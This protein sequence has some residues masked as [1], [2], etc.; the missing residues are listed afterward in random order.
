MENSIGK[1]IKNKISQ[2][3]GPKV[4]DAQSAEIFNTTLNKFP[5]ELPESEKVEATGAASAG[6]YSA[7]LFGDMK[8]DEETKNLCNNLFGTRT[9][10]L[11]KDEVLIKFVAHKL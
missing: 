8:E 1:Q 10:L 3:V 4:Q 5:S 9:T 2:I 11:R 7:P 6:G